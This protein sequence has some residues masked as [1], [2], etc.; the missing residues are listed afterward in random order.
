MASAH[1]FVPIK[2]QEVSLTSL[3]SKVSASLSAAAVAVVVSLFPANAATLDFSFSFSNA[4]NGG[5]TV[6]GV[7]R[8]LSEGTGAATSVEVTSNTL[9][10]GLG[11]YVGNP[12]SNSWT[13]AGGI[14]TDFL[15]VSFGEFNTLPAVTGATLFFDSSELIG[16]T[17]R[18]GLSSSPFFVNT[19]SSRVS[20]ADFG[21]T[22]EPLVAPVPLPAAG[23]MLLAGLGGLMVLRR[24]AA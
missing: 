16:A 17:F 24:R 8:G 11:E 6:S 5:G 12:D 18:A 7:V 10:F 15:F 13:V 14:V 19:G 9:G 23:L 2:S 1:S 3:K 20:T 21:L 4:L 22:F